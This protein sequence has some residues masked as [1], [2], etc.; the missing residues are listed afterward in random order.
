MA[1]SHLV[2]L[3][4]IRTDQHHGE[5]PRVTPPCGF[6]CAMLSVGEIVVRRREK[7]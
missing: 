7:N 1:E 4:F 3:S 5:W 2:S 6:L